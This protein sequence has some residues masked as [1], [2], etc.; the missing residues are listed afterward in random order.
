MVGVTE[1]KAHDV[2]SRTFEL[3]TYE[4]APGKMADLEARFRDHALPLFEEHGFE[5]I[6]MW[7][8]SNPADESMFVYLLA[9]PSEDAATKAWERFA[10]DP[11]WGRALR[12]TGL[13]GPLVKSM[14]SIFL[15]PAE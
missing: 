12:D 3:R 6:G 11:R 2:N 1:S 14:T 13:D 15:N 10:A 9:Y 8:P 5:V 4:V 7:T